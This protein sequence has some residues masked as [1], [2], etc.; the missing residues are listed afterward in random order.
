M[1]IGLLALISALA[2]MALA[3]SGAAATIVVPPATAIEATSSQTLFLPENAYSEVFVRCTSSV[4]RFK[5]PPGRKKGEVVRNGIDQN[6]NRTKVGTRSTGPGGVTA[7]L[8]E[9]PSF[10]GCGVF[11]GAT[12]LL[13]A[14]VKTNATNGSWSITA[15]GGNETEGSAAIGVPKEGALIET[16]LGN[17]KISPKESSVVFA[18]RYVNAT[19]TLTVDSQLAFEGAGFVSPAQFEATYKADEGLE[20]L[21]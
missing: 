10:S 9:P 14:T 20:V 11:E 8:T 4:A 6:V 2:V 5:T 15:N 3:A 17:I 7:D 19:R 12:E 1:S 18:P 21:P 13:P 16:A